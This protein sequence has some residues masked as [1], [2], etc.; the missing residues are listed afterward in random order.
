MSPAQDLSTWGA[1]LALIPALP[2]ACALAFGSSAM[3]ARPLSERAISRLTAI[4]FSLIFLASLA[5]LPLVW[6]GQA[7]EVSLGDWFSVAE[8]T[9]I[10][11]FHLDRLATAMMLLTAMFL[12]IIAKFS[13][14]YLHRDP[15]YLR[16]YALLNVFAAGMLLLVMSSSYELLFMG[17]ELVGVASTLLIA[18]F[19]ERDAPVRSAL[20]T[21]ATYRVADVGLL[22]AIFMLHKHLHASHFDALGHHDADP[23]MLHWATPIA[24]ALLLAAAGKSAQ[25]PLGG[26]L[27]RA[28]EGPTPSSALFYGA[29]S[30]HAGAYLLLRSIP[31]LDATP[32]ARGV[33]F[34]V[35]LLTT[36]HGAI[37]GRVQTDAKSTLAYA[38]MTQVGLIFA[39]IGAGLYTLASIWLVAHA[40]LRG[41]QLLRAPSALHD[42]QR[43]GPVTLPTPALPRWLYNLAIERFYLE[44]LADRLV[45]QPLQSA[46]RAIDHVERTLSGGHDTSTNGAEE[47]P[48]FATS[49]ALAALAAVWGVGTLVAQP[50]LTAAIIAAPLLTAA[51][52]LVAGPRRA[53]A[54]G[55]AGLGLALSL[56]ASIPIH[57][58]AASSEV[59]ALAWWALDL[60][61]ANALLTPLT[62]LLAL[63]S[64]L[65]LP[66]KLATPRI[67]AATLALSA[68]NQAVLLTHH[69]V[70]FTLAWIA[71]LALLSW[72]V[73]QGGGVLTARVHARRV[74]M[75]HAAG[76]SLAL[77][78]GVA[79]IA[80]QA[81]TDALNLRAAA[82]LEIAPSSQ[83]LIGLLLG[84]AILARS[85]VFPLH[86]WVL[87]TLEA[88][89]IVAGIPLMGL[90]LGAWALA[91]NVTPLLPA[92]HDSL[93]PVLLVVALAQTVYGALLALAQRS[94]HRVIG[95]VAISL[96]G[97]SF[98][99][100]SELSTLTIDGAILLSLG[101]GLALSGLLLVA[102]ALQAR[103][104]STELGR[105][106][107][108][109]RAMPRL[110]ALGFIFTVA[111]FGLPGTLSFVAGD[112]VMQGTYALHPAAALVVLACVALNGVSLTRAWALV[113]LGA[114]KRHV[115]ARTWT[116]AAMD[117]RP[118]EHGVALALALIVL[119][120]GLMPARLLSVEDRA[121]RDVAHQEDQAPT[122]HTLSE[123]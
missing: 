47:A 43:I 11:G 32:I 94:L 46:A 75:R 96:A 116:P 108:L 22:G 26:W 35:G 56:I 59:S 24:L 65:G 57:Q 6:G 20:T 107:G 90:P 78:A 16:F 109:V 98:V 68:A 15:G 103:A 91:H 87:P 58:H 64:I 114:P 25:L 39:L 120:G 79:L 10:G 86:T 119:L 69:L 37:A 83:I 17:W 101:T 72:L 115:I 4:T 5:L 30:V 19:H 41:F 81:R 67:L 49:P 77:I 50:D 63:I 85:A 48:T 93:M 89:P 51:I 111:T 62:G 9:F 99:G 29:L 95:A 7:L 100:I 60:D 34:A 27:P 40:T 73:G 54:A 88:A 82:A 112:L 12:G 44:A 117:V 2:A 61:D 14:N 1:A 97:I 102:G 110:T 70:T 105:L 104:G 45:T 52:L 121:A 38:I 8:Y 53:L 33:I 80:A 36:I 113:F 123:K 42:L 66:R 28:M 84:A 13:N 92:A 106:G 21:F 3:L 76:A 18:Y 118:R 122:P 55:G 71:Q 23:A 74:F 31:I